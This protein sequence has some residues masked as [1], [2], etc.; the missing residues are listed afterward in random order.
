[1]LL[2][3]SS[4]SCDCVFQEVE[5]AND[6]GKDAYVDLSE[7][8]NVTGLCVAVQVKGGASYRRPG[9]YGIPLDEDH[10]TLWRHSSIPVA[11]IVYDP[12]DRQLRW[13]NISGF[14]Q[15]VNK[16]LPSYIPIDTASVLSPGTL[17][18]A[19]KACFHSHRLQWVA[20]PALLRLTSDDESERYVALLDCFGIGRSDPGVLILLRHLIGMFKDEQLMFVI[21]ILAHATPHP[22]IF[23]HKGNWIPEPV[24]K[25]VQTHFQWSVEEIA[26]LMRAAPWELWQRGCPGQDVYS[27]I[28][29]DRQIEQKMGDVA[30]RALRDG[31]DELAFSAMYLAIYW[32]RAEGYEMY[33]GF[34]GIDRRFRNLS[35]SSELEDLLK[36][37]GRV[38]LFE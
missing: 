20:G 28:C 17:H 3:H 2:G 15:T 1:M 33:K 4:K 25:K 30:I 37:F 32:A 26:T 34:L 6:Y 24:C 10:A 18:T 21:R 5:L 35:P 14:L 7:G 13:C 22:D 9:G 11:G 16:P 12:E 27:L 29:M 38:T 23:W 8:D 19:F 36:Q 31:D